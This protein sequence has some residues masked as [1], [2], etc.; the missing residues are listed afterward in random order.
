M[1]VVTDYAATNPGTVTGWELFS[2]RRSSILVQFWRRIKDQLFSIVG[3]TS[4]EIQEGYNQKL[5]LHSDRYTVVAGDVVG[6]FVDG[7]QSVVFTTGSGDLVWPT[8]GTDGIVRNLDLSRY[9]NGWDRSY[10]IRAQ[11]EPVC[12]TLEYWEWSVSSSIDRFAVCNGGACHGGWCEGC[13]PMVTGAY[14]AI[15][16]ADSVAGSITYKL[17]NGYDEARV[18]VGVHYDGYVRDCRGVMRVGGVDI[19]TDGKWSEK[20]NI[21]FS[22]KPGDILELGENDLC[23]LV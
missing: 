5:L 2:N 21:T 19:F 20:V 15:W 13:T 18:M 10:A 16:A 1:H 17:P 6:F 4:W 12:A 9:T 7:K 8:H 23:R 3:S 14:L 22:Y 11:V